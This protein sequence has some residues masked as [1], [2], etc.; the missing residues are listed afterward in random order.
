MFIRENR[1]RVV[2]CQTTTLALS[3]ATINEGDLVEDDKNILAQNQV[4]LIAVVE[5]INLD[6]DSKSKKSRKGVVDK[7]IYKDTNE[8]RPPPLIIGTTHLKSAKSA[9]G[10]RYRQKGVQQI[11]DTVDRIY[12]NL[13][14]AG[15]PP[16]VILTG[17]FNAVPEVSGYQPL[18]YR[19]VKTHKLGLRSIYNEDIQQSPIR[20]SSPELY[21]TWKRKSKNRTTQGKEGLAL[22]KEEV[23][24]RCIDYIFYTPY[25][26][27]QNKKDYGREPVVAY[28]ESQVAIS[29]LLRLAVYLFSA[30]VPLTSM[31]SSK[32]ESQ[33]KVFV[34]SL[35]L[36]GLAIFEMAAEGTIFKP[37]IAARTISL[38]SDKKEKGGTLLNKVE[39]KVE[40]LGK[41]IYYIGSNGDAPGMRAT[42]ALDL[43][44]EEEMGPNLIPSESYPSDHLSIA[45]DFQI[46]F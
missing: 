16:N 44:S 23:I 34:I 28:S 36:I 29:I 46:I 13:E 9:S 24:K 45:A 37:Q 39:A 35:A 4:G 43:Y 11:L 19:A 33:D 2:S 22:G 7:S 8:R 14:A 30:V 17:D 1:F 31:I 12:M 40:E 6:N 10:E 38:Q 32:L 18:T 15:C 27:Q 25:T 20:L 21:T 26:L 5:F 42:A 41:R 3:I